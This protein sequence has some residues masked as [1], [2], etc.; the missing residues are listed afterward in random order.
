MSLGVI[1][2][3]DFIDSP[4]TLQFIDNILGYSTEL[5]SK[6]LFL[7]TSHAYLN[8]RTW[9]NQAGTDQEVH[10]NLETFIVLEDAMNSTQGKNNHQ[11]FPAINSKTI[12][13]T[14]LERQDYCCNRAMNM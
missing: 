6:T 5:D 10:S 9:K 12:I 11:H 7:K 13:I 2:H 14:G 8:H 4:K 1:K 3:W